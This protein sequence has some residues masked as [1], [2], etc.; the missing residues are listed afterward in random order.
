MKNNI[1]VSHFQWI[2]PKSGTYSLHN[3][4]CQLGVF[5]CLILLFA[6]VLD[7]LISCGNCCHNCG[8]L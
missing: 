8:A 1:N 7:S 6:R 4:H 2:K 3:L 5:H